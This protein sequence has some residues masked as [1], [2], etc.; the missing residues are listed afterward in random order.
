MINSN[1]KRIPIAEFDSLAREN[2]FAEG[3]FIDTFGD[4][5]GEPY[6]AKRRVFG[7]LKDGRKVESEKGGEA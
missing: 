6:M 3:P 1:Y 2:Q 4:G 5:Y 7:T